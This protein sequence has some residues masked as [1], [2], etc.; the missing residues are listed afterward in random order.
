MLNFL[1]NFLNSIT[2]YRLMLY[3]LSALW[4]I[5]LIFS[6]LGLIPVNPVS[7]VF[8]TL[9]ILVICWSTNKILAFA[10]KAPTNIESVY[11]TA[12]ILSFILETTSLKK[13]YFFINFV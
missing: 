8:S 5:A 6:F 9:L 3:F 10:F 1:D 4:V 11:I 7:I 12:F 13:N 2:M